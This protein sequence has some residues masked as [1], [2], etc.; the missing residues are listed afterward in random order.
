MLADAPHPQGVHPRNLPAPQDHLHV[1]RR[2]YETL[3][4]T[5]REGRRPWDITRSPTPRTHTPSPPASVSAQTPG[6]T[7][8]TPGAP[9]AR[10]HAAPDPSARGATT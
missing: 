8:S 10:Q 9:R 5:Q 6:S 3:Q 7:H 2:L 4:E 1:L